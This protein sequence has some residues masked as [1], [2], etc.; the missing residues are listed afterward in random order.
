MIIALGVVAVLLGSL[1]YSNVILAQSGG[2]YDPWIDYN[3]DGIVDVND[4]HSLGQVYSASGDPTKYVT[5]TNWPISQEFHVWYQDPLTGSES[6]WSPYYNASGF[7]SLHILVR[8]FD[9]KDVEQLTFY[10]YGTLWKEDHTSWYPFETYR[11]TLTS[12]TSETDIHLPVPSELF[13]FMVFAPPGTT[14]SIYMSFY[15]TW[16]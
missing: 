5:V 10:V 13:R 6:L 15:M 1:F 16:S 4:L 9:L 3:E 12:S 7:S 11:Y 8:G 2:E 14:G